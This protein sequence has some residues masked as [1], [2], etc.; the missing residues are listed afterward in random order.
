MNVTKNNPRKVSEEGRNNGRKE[1]HADRSGKTH[2]DFPLSLISNFFLSFYSSPSTAFIFS[3]LQ[4]FL[5]RVVLI[6]CIDS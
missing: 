1:G 6:E 2:G 5:F 3:L 4:L